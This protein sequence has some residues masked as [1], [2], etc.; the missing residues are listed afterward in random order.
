MITKQQ[1]FDLVEDI[2]DE[3]VLEQVYDALN[4]IKV[5]Q[6]TNIWASLSPLQKEAVNR[7]YEQSKDSSKLIEHQEVK[8]RLSKWL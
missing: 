2:E 8:E 6:D 1:I 3:S 5:S 4:Y 7:S